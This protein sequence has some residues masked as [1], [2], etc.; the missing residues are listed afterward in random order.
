MFFLNPSMQM[1]VQYNELGNDYFLPKCF[2]F[3]INSVTHNPCY[4]VWAAEGTVIPTNHS[5]IQFLLQIISSVS[6]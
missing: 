6:A 3:I 4:A 2:Q 1:P 5:K